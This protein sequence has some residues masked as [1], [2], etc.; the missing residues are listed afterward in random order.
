MI[1]IKI[2]QIL[3]ENTMTRTFPAYKIAKQRRQIRHLP[4]LAPISFAVWT[5]FSTAVLAD[6]SAE[7]TLPRI[8][9]VG[10]GAESISR[11]PGSVSLVTKEA[12]LVN[13]PLSTQDAIKF[14][15][16]VVVREEEGYGFIPNIGMRGLDPN[17]SQKLLVLE[18]GVPIAPSLFISNESYYTAH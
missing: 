8:E 5:L 4:K 11:L 6:E 12:I 10:Q 17:R 1:R 15:P 16:G 9:V 14:V 3:L 2:T 13:Q 7:K 18:D